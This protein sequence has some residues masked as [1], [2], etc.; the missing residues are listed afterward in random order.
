MLRHIAAAFAT[1]AFLVL[2]SPASH[3]W[4]FPE[5]AEITR[6]ALT[7][8]APAP[9]AEAIQHAVD[10][11]SE[12]VQ[13]PYSK[14]RRCIP[15]SSLPLCRSVALPFHAVPLAASPSE[16]RKTPRALTTPYAT[17]IS[18]GA[19]P[20]LAGDHATNID[21]LER[22]LRVEVPRA[23]LPELTVAGM[24]VGAS[25]ET[26]DDFRLSAPIEFTRIFE[27]SSPSSSG[28]VVT[29]TSLNRRKLIRDLDGRLLLVDHDYT[30]RA[31]GTKSHFQDAVT[32]IPELLRTLEV[33][34]NTDN[35]L[36]QMLAHHMRS[37]MLALKAREGE[38]CRSPGKVK[39][40]VTP[41]E[42]RVFTSQ[43][44]LEHAFA[45]H[46]MEDA[47]AAGHIATEH[48]FSDSTD[49]LQRHDYLSRRGL[50][51]RRAFATQACQSTPRA[52][53]L[54]YCW[55]AYGDGYLD[56]DTLP[57]VAEATARLQLQFALALK[58][59]GWWK[60]KLRTGSCPFWSEAPDI[61]KMTQAEADLT[62][63]PGSSCEMWRVARMLD[64][65]PSWTYSNE[66]Q[67]GTLPSRNN[68]HYRAAM[69]IAGAMEAM[70]HIKQTFV[71]AAPRQLD[72]AHSISCGGDAGAQRAA[73]ELARSLLGDPISPCCE[74]KSELEFCK[75]KEG[76]ATSYAYSF[77][78][79]PSCRSEANRDSADPPQLRW[80]RYGDPAVSLWRP[81]LVV[82]PASQ[83]DIRTLDGRDSFGRGLAFQVGYGA[84]MVSILGHENAGVF[85]L[86]VAAGLSY[87]AD[88][89]LPGRDNRAVLEVN[90]GLAPTLFV[91]MPYQA[92]GSTRYATVAFTE[93][94]SPI[95]PLATL[96]FG[97]LTRSAD[98]VDPVKAPFGVGL[99]G[100][101]AYGLVPSTASFGKGFDFLGWDMELAY[102]SLDRDQPNRTASVGVAM[103]PELRFRIGSSR[104]VDSIVSAGNA[105]MLQQP[106]V[107]SGKQ[108]TLSLEFAGGFSW[109]L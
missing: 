100:V 21:E 42:R 109:F 46:F 65:I 70:E 53:E 20:A 64:P 4:F 90:V 45:L 87:R 24:V 55:T 62:D 22:L 88:S 5:H 97:Y 1:A 59:K 77:Y 23:F 30:S 94:R 80:V 73:A 92:D 99:F 37:I 7:K 29:S 32:P 52:G 85:G 17:C 11:A 15:Y 66:G 3:A 68:H 71:A 36:N 49:R 27:G 78:M 56:G 13:D 54:P 16:Q 47:F 18:Y 83:A 57:Y 38:T 44:L 25:V 50:A 28:V 58:D 95:V 61:M 86:G 108:L 69:V 40:C 35:A 91:G 9:V 107:K 93:V 74:R 60:S 8:Y 84:T 41:E 12:C 98:A 34:G 67:V 101:R 19:L 63:V 10:V 76:I 51:V 106:Y 48:G 104:A 79:E 2:Y 31:A 72:I 81:L 82:W 105:G 26:W 96:L 102:V 75:G 89:L 39:P 43:A 6:I 14:E 103:D 33:A